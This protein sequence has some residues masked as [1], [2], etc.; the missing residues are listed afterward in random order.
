MGEMPTIAHYHFEGIPQIA[1][2]YVK[3]AAGSGGQR[4]HYS[5]LRGVRQRRGVT[6][7]GERC[8]IV[9]DVIEESTCRHRQSNA[10][11]RLGFHPSV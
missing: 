7:K 10:G 1:E 6:P 4:F 3:M 9:A 11:W 5:L 8:R 2:P